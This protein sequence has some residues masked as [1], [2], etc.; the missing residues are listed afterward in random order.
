MDDSD[1]S[2]QIDEIVKKHL[3]DGIK[4]ETITILSPKRLDRSCLAAADNLSFNVADI[5][6]TGLKRR[7]GHE[8]A[9]STIHAFKGLESS[10][11][12][13]TDITHMDDDR[14]RAL[15]YVGMSRARYSLSV[16]I[17]NLARE[18][19]QAA[20]RRNLQKGTE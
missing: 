1:Q 12:I 3:A 15:L 17:S 2:R 19:Y 18:E 9:F 5:T 6:G 11:V 13:V 16:L 8:I 7:H 20:I 4:I 10:I 14:N